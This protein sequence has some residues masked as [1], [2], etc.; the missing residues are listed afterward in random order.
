M[1][2]KCHDTKKARKAEIKHRL[3]KWPNLL[4]IYL[5]QAHDEPAG[6]EEAEA[7]VGAHGRQQTADGWNSGNVRRNRRVFM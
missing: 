5:S 7:G 4:V 2:T 6:D 1:I 3:Q